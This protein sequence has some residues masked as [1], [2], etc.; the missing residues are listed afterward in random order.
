MAQPWMFMMMMMMMICGLAGGEH[1]N[2]PSVT[3]EHVCSMQLYE[4]RI[5]VANT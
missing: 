1:A 5:S 4:T 2:D 3:E